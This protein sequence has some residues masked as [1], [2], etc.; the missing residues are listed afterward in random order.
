MKITLIYPSQTKSNRL[1][2]WRQPRHHKYPG[3][4][5]LT[6]ASLSPSSA[7][8]QIIDDD[9]DII[10]YDDYPDIVGLSALTM[11]VNR[12]YEIAKGFREKNIPVVMGGMHVSACPEEALQF[13]DA[14]VIGEAEDTWPVVLDDLNRGQL[15]KIYRSKNNYPLANS[16][17]LKREL[18]RKERYLIVN[19]IQASRGCPQK[20]E[21]C[22]MTSIIGNGTR[23]RPVREVVDEIKSLRGRYFVLNDDNIAQKF[24]YYKELFENLIPL[25]K[26]WAAQASWN[27][28]KDKELLSLIAQSGCVAL[29]I[30]FDSFFPQDGVKKIPTGDIAKTYKEAVK[31]IHSFNIC[32]FGAFVLGFDTEDENI[33]CTVLNFALESKME[34]AQFNI[35]TPY[36]GTLLYKRL[37]NENRL[38]EKNWNNYITG[39]LCFQ[40]KTMP[41]EIFIQK[42]KWLK[43]SFYSYKGIS[44]RVFQS[45]GRIKLLETGMLL[46]INLGYKK[47]IDTYK[48]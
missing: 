11:N 27:I 41:R 25:K 20:C 8:I 19:T 5:L 33:F 7:N 34:I 3:L 28:I 2:K 23:T 22:S 39:N 30:G 31:L 42:Y 15:K 16:P 45:I 13:A 4:G 6:V 26:R 9:Y 40:L 38:V 18:L 35:L 24:D 37:A 46:G 36:P 43:R 21:F 14:I 12:A 44:S 10:D 32:V 1:L 48:V 17:P 47:S 29:H